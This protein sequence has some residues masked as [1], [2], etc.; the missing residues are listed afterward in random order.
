MCLQFLVPELLLRVQLYLNPK[1]IH[2]FRKVSSH[3]IVIAIVES[4]SS[5][6]KSCTQLR[7]N[8][9]F[10]SMLSKRFVQNSVPSNRHS[11]LTL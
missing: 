1:D 3:H 7:E 11:P 6:V 8:D 10:G 2:S 9:Q 4:V 5:A